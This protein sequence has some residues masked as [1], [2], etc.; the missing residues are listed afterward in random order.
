MKDLLERHWHHLPVDEVLEILDADRERGLDLFE[1][2]RRRERMGPNRLTPRK[3]KSPLVKFL[4]QFNNPLVLIL[5]VASAV[6]AAFK[7]PLDAGVI[8]GVVLVNAVIGYVQEA[9]AEESIAALARAMTAEAD[10]VRS[11]KAVRVPAEELVP[12][13]I[14]VLQAGARVPA[15]LRLLAA[16]DL[17]IAEA[18][19]TGESVAV[20]KDAAAACMPEAV[21]AER[22]TMAYASTLVTYG[23]GRGVVAAIGDATEI[24]RISQLISSAAELQTPL[25]RKLE[26]FSRILLAAILCLAGATFAI[27]LARGQAA[28]ETLMA[29]VALAVGAIP[30]GLPA[31]VTVTL[32]IGVSRM[33]RRRAIIRN[34]PAVETLGSTTV[35]CSDKTGT[36]TQNQMTV[37]EIATLGGAY[38]VE[39]A[40]Y[41]PQGGIRGGWESDHAAR[42]TLLAGLL[43]ND[44][45]L[46]QEGGSWTVRGDPTEGALLA[47]A[48]KA[49]LEL[50]PQ[51]HPLRLDLIPFDSQHQ[52]MA[53]LHEGGAVYVK[54][55][56]ERLLERCAG[57]LAPGGSLEECGTDRFRAEAD[58][59]AAD[60]LRVLAF[61]RKDLPG[62]DALSHEDIRGLTLLG[63]QGMIDPPR[64]EAVDAV[65]ACK[66]AGIAVKMITGD[67]ALT[68]AAVGSQ[69]GLCS[70]D[71]G[72]VLTGAKLA[73]LSDA[74]L[75]ERAGNTSVFARVAP[76]Q[77]LRLVEALQSRGHV[78]AMTGD[79]VNDAP[80]LKQSD[81]GVAMGITGTDV[82]KEA[83]DM[84]LTDDNFASIEAAVEEGRGVFD[85]LTKFIAWTL[86]TNLGEGMILLAAILLGG[87]LP[88][89]PIQILWINMVTTAVLG[90]TL[91]LEPKERDIM[92]RPPRDPK[93]PILDGVLVGRILLVSLLM[94]AGAFGLFEYEILRGASE[95]E[96]RT[97]AVNV[98]VFVETLY[99]FNARSLKR[100]VFQLGLLSNPWVLGGAL[101]MAAIQVGFTYLPF[102]QRLFG[103]AGI[104]GYLW[105]DVIGVSLAAYAV[106]EVEKGL[107]RRFGRSA[108]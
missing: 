68:A 80:A 91:A 63:L 41:A 14:V 20:E 92:R 53:T 83:A 33:A 43:C 22:A 44:S 21:L 7:D 38:A 88:I 34:L 79:G 29:A 4:L 51:A 54:G 66:R 1:V 65:A 99:L 8:F 87:A 98:I 45:R 82:A 81:I 48:G 86:P 103:S 39:G 19:L 60:G 108:A 2:R 85:N 31:A 84:I 25:T 67:H 28:V 76:E 6:T 97:V 13:D 77:K 35:I 9:R 24:G 75:I 69:I 32:A 78:V 96:A 101:L 74:E 107:R 72:D 94:L 70:A 58:R 17:Q 49:A 73:E 64:P 59:M 56:A 93:A 16:R 23:T 90:M 50:D 102:M 42:E 5:V 95:A 104:P 55:A 36:L 27:G 11:G 61:A 26:R 40:G 37:K 10:V 12:G 52:Y 18:A 30:E 89:L 71:C 15:D 105:L 47:A 46:E 106:V 100:S 62:R 57:A 3:G